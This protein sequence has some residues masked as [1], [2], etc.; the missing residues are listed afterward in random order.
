MSALT[1]LVGFWRT[2][3]RKDRLDSELDLELGSAL[4]TYTA[5]YTAEGMDPRAARRAA[6]L[7]FGGI[8]QVKDA[9]RDHRTGANVEAL[10]FDIRYAAR[11]LRRTPALAATIVVTL[12][13]GIGGN[14]AMFSVVR[15]T[16]F[17]P[18]PYRDPSRLVFVWLGQDRIGYRGPMSG[19]D[20]RAL[21]EG[22]SSF[23]GFGAIWAS[24]AIT[25]TGNGDPEQ[26][27][28]AMVTTNFFDVLGARVALG[29]NFQPGDQ[30]AG[31]GATVI[32]GWELFQRRFG[33]DRSLVG[34][35][36]EVN[37]SRA[38]VVGILPPDFRLFLP[39]DASVPDRLQA[40]TPFWPDFE[41]GP[42]GSLFLRVIGRMRPNVPFAQARDEVSSVAKGIARE[43]G[44][45]RILTAHPLQDDNV[46]PIRGTMLAL[47]AGVA[48]LLL[49][50][51]VNVASLLVAR[52]ATR[53]SEVGLQL[54]LGASRR[55][56]ARLVL[57]EGL[58]LAML[59]M[60]GGLL[61]AWFTLRILVAVA[62]PSLSQLDGA[63]V[64]APMFG[65]LSAISLLAGLIFSTAPQIELFKRAARGHA[66]QPE[67]QTTASLV[68]RRTRVL[69]VVVQVALSVVLLIS[70]GLLTRAFIEVLRVDPGFRSATQLTF[71]IAVP[72]RYESP[73][74]FNA[75]AANL[76]SRLRALPGVTGGGAISHV[77]YDDMPNWSLTYSPDAPMPPDAARQGDSRAI[78]TGLLEALGV[79]LIDGRFF[80][81]HDDDASRPVAIIDDRLAGELWPNQ[82]AVGRQISTSVSGMNADV[83]GNTARLTIVG[84]VP[85]LRLRSLVEDFRPEIFVPWR[86]AQRN[87]MAFVLD[88]NRES[89]SLAAD[90]R[91]A[92]AAVDPLVAIYDIRS[93]RTYV[94]D[95]RA[96]RR[97]TVLLAVA[98]ACMAL[99]LTTIGVYGLLAHTVAIRRHEIGVRRALGATSSQVTRAILSEGF[100]LAVVGC[101]S[102]LAG[103]AAVAGLLQSQLYAVRPRDPMA[104]GAGVAVI[105]IGSAIACWLPARRAVKVS[106][107]DALRIE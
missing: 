106:P 54:A 102:G 56:I 80:T 12:A 77:P 33:G 88:T 14:A 5:R 95:A 78:S 15:A 67:R 101:A 22:A 38:T 83:G 24:S 42:R 97:F 36:I 45:N 104:Y 18:L 1:R 30:A 48:L 65:F 44:R 89:A 39:A 58:L 21:R 37:E 41:N 10:F 76:Q 100:G 86:I 107:M 79:P 63:T 35:T 47:F 8:S 11:G 90:I 26:L 31:P 71:R 69:L 81:D 99:G 74:A 25:L 60:A 46:A 53:A 27:R 93:L 103:A 4:D 57:F 66:L 28:A 91:T 92:I 84:V 23:D 34:R 73:A 62:P 68:R 29:R 13:L 94:V 7:A 87:P 32:L 3:F 82:R 9:V 49:I 17:Q 64:D 96:T 51:C 98:F 6:A 75:F 52:A 50:V 55:R 40:F 85:H 105:L 16:L 61:T 70:A 72:G 2:L 59:G 20:L 43:S 19:P